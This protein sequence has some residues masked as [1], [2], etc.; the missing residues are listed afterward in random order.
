MFEE[1][2]SKFDSVFKKLRGRGVL[3]ESNVKE[4]LRE[5][6]ADPKRFVE[7][8]LRSANFEKTRQYLDRLASLVSIPGARRL[9]RDVAG[10]EAVINGAAVQRLRA[11]R[12][13]LERE[14]SARR[15]DC[16]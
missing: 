6:F 10:E 7:T 4:G 15:G 13:R 11:A 2:S 1:L 8:E 5:N 9:L 14:C 16:R 3:T 12:T